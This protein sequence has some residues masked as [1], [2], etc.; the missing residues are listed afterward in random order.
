MRPYHL[1]NLQVGAEQQIC[2]WDG[3]PMLLVQGESLG[4]RAI[5]DADPYP[6]YRSLSAGQP[7]AHGWEHFD[8]EHWSCD[9]LF[10]YW[11]IS[12]DAWAKEE[13]RQ[14]GQSLKGL[15]RLAYYYTQSVQAA[16]AE[17][18]CLQGFAQIY[19]ATRDESL[20]TYAMRRINE[21]VDTQRHKTHASRAM[22]F[23]DNY[24]NTGYPLNHQ[25]FMAWQHGAVLYGFLGAYK[26]FHEPVL[27]TIAEDVAYTVEYSWVTNYTSPT[28]GFVAQGLRYYVP[29]TYNGAP[30][31]ANNWD[32]LAQGIKFGDSPL[33]G[34]HTFL[35]GG[36]HHLAN[37][38]ADAGVRTRALQYGGILRGAVVPD[39]DR[40]NKWFYCLP[41]NRVQ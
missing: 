35:I 18:W 27:L 16:R 9:L 25:F 36:L 14:L 21:I 31:P 3:T 22:T 34:A 11:T 26:A 33:G 29:A 13:L 6:Q 1:W 28:F 8:H 2:L 23:Q 37:M 38:T 15:M 32:G 39:S 10:D 20:K 4:R 30:V 12:G 17:G 41:S 5:R 7:R 40:W 19:Q 24:S